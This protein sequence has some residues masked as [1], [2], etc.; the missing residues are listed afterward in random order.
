MRNFHSL[1]WEV[2]YSAGKILY[3]N[4]AGLN[5]NIKGSLSRL[6]IKKIPQ[7]NPQVFQP[8]RE[9]AK[10]G[11]A[12]LG[13]LYDPK[14]IDKIAT[15]FNQFIEDD[16]SGYS[17]VLVDGKE[18]ARAINR[19]FTIIPES[20]ELINDKVRNSLENYYG[21]YFKVTFFRFQRNYHVPKEILDK[22][23]VYSNRWH[24]DADDTTRVK[25]LVYLTDVTEK[26]GPFH[27][28][29]RERTKELMRMGFGDRDHFNISSQELEKHQKKSIGGKGMAFMCNCEMGLHRAGVPEKGHYRDHILFQFAPSNKPLPKDWIKDF[30][31]P[32]DGLVGIN[33]T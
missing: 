21:G 11:Y 6:K 7:S 1:L 31:D 10:N 26:D 33:N 8:M 9:F 19:G 24:C 16:R 29:P 12:V 5:N 18:Y 4:G 32:Y 13:N 28:Q 15:K 20:L 23:E 27:I 25:M 3:K 2:N 14:L 30:V 17:S 22:T